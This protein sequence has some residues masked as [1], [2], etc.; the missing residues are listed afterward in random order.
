MLR[1]DFDRFI[2]IAKTELP[3]DL[4]L[5]SASATKDNDYSVP[6]RVRDRHS[7]I[8][9]THSQ[10]HRQRGIFI[11]IL[12]ID[13]FHRNPLLR[14]TQ[15]FVK[16]IYRNLLKVHFPPSRGVARPVAVLLH[17]ILEAL[18]PIMTSETPIKTFRNFIRKRFI[19][20][21]RRNSGTGD[22]GYGFDVRWARIF[23]RADVFPIERI[24]F[25]DA[26]FCAPH[27]PDGVLRVFYGSD[28][29]T[30]PPASKRS[31]DHFESV[32]LD[33]RIDTTPVMV[34]CKNVERN[35]G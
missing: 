8:I 31:R 2:E 22:L 33:I 6:C 26:D 14:S 7:R 10:V 30:P 1:R 17:R 11:D 34:S 3:D 25:E 35:D 28:Y 19:Y 32:I 4:E 29:M 12:P 9:N 13:E 5:E 16:F 15:R 27:N 18:S 20:N 23:E 24:K 21:A